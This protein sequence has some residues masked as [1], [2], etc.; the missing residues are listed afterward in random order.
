MCDSCYIDHRRESKKKSDKQLGS[1]K[2]EQRVQQAANRYRAKY[3]INRIKPIRYCKC[4]KEALRTSKYCFCADCSI[5][6]RKGKK[7]EYQQERKKNHLPTK[8]RNN[9]SSRLNRALKH[10][11]GKSCSVIKYLGCSI[12]EYILYLESKFQEGMT[13]DN[14]G[15]EWHIDHIK[16][17]STDYSDLSLHHY[18]NTQPLWIF[19]HITK[20]AKENKERLDG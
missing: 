19:E 13:W 16:P 10:H 8:I 14:Y 2:K 11:G 3:R 6:H 20:T 9:I 15:S 4:G 7:I 17:L 18:T 5:K 12:K 1:D